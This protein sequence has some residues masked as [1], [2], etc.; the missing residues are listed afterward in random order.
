MLVLRS[1][2]L[3]Q[4]ASSSG[5]PHARTLLKNSMGFSLMELIIVITVIGIMAA[6][7]IPMMLSFIQ[8]SQTRGAAQ[9]LTTLLNHARQLAITNNSSY[10]VEVQANPQ[11]RM[12]F[13]AGTTTPCTDAN[14][15]KGPGT[16]GSG[17]RSL[18]NDV[19]IT[20]ASATALT[21]SSLGAATTAG[22]VRVQNSGGT[23]CLDAVV[24][25]SGRIRSQAAAA[26]P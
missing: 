22:T 21:F 14:A 10:S 16:D 26:C 4:G 13:C 8:A 1:P 7:S 9:E 3:R 6:V 25:P 24:S 12:R 18:A 23:S 2:N 5:A 20:A 19:R 11:N 15:W 17:W